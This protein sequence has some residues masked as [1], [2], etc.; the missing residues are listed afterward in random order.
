M[1]H[2]QS[3]GDGRVE[4]ADLELRILKDSPVSIHTQIIEQLK[5]MIRSVDLAP[6][7]RLPAGRDLADV[8]GVNRNT[9]QRAYQEL[10]RLGFVRTRQGSGTFVVGSPD[11][12]GSNVYQ[13]ARTEIR[14]A[15]ASLARFIPI[16]DLAGIVHAELAQLAND[17]DSDLRNL[18]ETRNIYADRPRKGGAVDD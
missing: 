2:N 15:L 1:Q 10:E 12:P 17:R 9:V 11:E 18:I 5:N 16:N 7:S 8:L 13:R 14:G 6:G 3:D 4:V